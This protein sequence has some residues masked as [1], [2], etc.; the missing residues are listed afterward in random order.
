MTKMAI[1]PL[2][3]AALFAL[4]APA[5]AT[6]PLQRW[7]QRHHLHGAW[8]A[9][10]AD[11]DGIANRREYTLHTDPRRADSDRDGLRDGDELRIAGDPRN[12]DT[13]HD[14]IRDG[15][16]HAGVI[17][18]FDG[19]V[20]TLRQFSDHRQ[21]DVTVDTPVT[22]ADE[23]YVDVTE[24]GDDENADATPPEP[25]PESEDETVIDLSDDDVTSCADPRIKPGALIS[26]LELTD[27]D[28]ERIVTAIDFGPTR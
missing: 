25:E 27:L 4:S 24:T 11:H 21:I 17:T 16:E 22:C 10:D 26:S 1:A 5:Y 7:A 3:A 13:D 9:K 19:T 2:L 18:A 14:G 6:S 28:G 12:P 20:I 8:Q 15:D 23:G